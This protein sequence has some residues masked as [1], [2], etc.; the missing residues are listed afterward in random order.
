[1]M[2]LIPCGAQSFF[3]PNLLTELLHVA[4]TSW[5]VVFR[6]HLCVARASL[7]NI[8]KRYSLLSNVP[9]A[10]ATVTFGDVRDVTFGNDNFTVVIT[11]RKWQLHCCGVFVVVT[12]LRKWQLRRRSVNRP[13]GWFE[14]ARECRVW[15]ASGFS[16]FGLP[17]TKIRAIHDFHR[18]IKMH[19]GFCTPTPALH[20]V[21][22]NFLTESD[23][24]SVAFTLKP[25]KPSC[26]LKASNRRAVVPIILNAC[27][28][29]AP[30]NRR[31]PRVCKTY[32][33]EILN[34]STTKQLFKRVSLNQ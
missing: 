17:V 8:L 13:S 19:L 22:Q 6:L 29:E 24:S 9:V 31:N 30:T 5:P 34:H 26:L 16:K 3:T 21:L 14:V 18:V 23:G 33:R 25:V 20:Q 4:D 2:S 11:L 1:M 32:L 15:T 7:L 12:A 28:W 10:Q 27:N